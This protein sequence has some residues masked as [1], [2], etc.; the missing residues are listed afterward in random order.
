MITDAVVRA[1]ADGCSEI[2]VVCSGGPDIWMLKR[3]LSENFGATKGDRLL[4]MVAHGIR[5]TLVPWGEK[6]QKRDFCRVLVHDA[7]DE[8]GV[9]WARKNI[10]KG[11]AVEEV[12][13]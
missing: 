5:F 13:A 4:E 1:A 10:A 9:E 7:Y 6:H 2:A 12:F 8:D 3:V 11:C